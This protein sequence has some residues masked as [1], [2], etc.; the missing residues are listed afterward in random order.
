MQPENICDPGG[1]IKDENVSRLLGE[2]NTDGIVQIVKPLSGSRKSP[3]IENVFKV[4]LL[5]LSGS[6]R[7]VSAV[8]IGDPQNL[9]TEYQNFQEFV[10]KGPLK[11]EH[12]IGLYKPICYL[13]NTGLLQLDFVDLENYRPLSVYYSKEDPIPILELLLNEVLK[14]WHT[15]NN[16]TKLANLQEHIQDQLGSHMDEI[17]EASNMLFQDFSAYAECLI[18]QAKKLV[19]NCVNLIETGNFQPKKNSEFWTISSIVHGDLNFNNIFV[20]DQKKIKL[21]DYEHTGEGFL[22]D[23]LARIECEIKFNMLKHYENRDFWEA[24]I[25]FEQFLLN[26]LTFSSEELPEI[27]KEH[28]EI[29]KAVKC[30]DIVRK[31]AKEVTNYHYKL[32]ESSYWAELLT[33]TLK[34]VGYSG[35]SNSQKKY[36]LISSL[37]IF[38]NHFRPKTFAEVTDHI[39]IPSGPHYPPDSLLTQMTQESKMDIS[40]D[41]KED[42]QLLIRALLNGHVILFLGPEAP[43]EAGAPT[44][45]ELAVKMYDK[46]LGLKPSTNDPEVI[47]DNLLSR[48]DIRDQVKKDIM[49]EYETISVQG[50]YR[51]LPNIRWKRI[52]VDYIDFFV[53]KAYEEAEFS[54]QRFQNRFDPD[55]SREDHDE[56]GNNVVI[57]RVSGSARFYADE[58]RPMRLGAREIEAGK[59]VRIEWFKKLRDIR[60]PI[61]VLFYGYRW[62]DLKKTFFEIVGPSELVDK[63][64]DFYWVSNA[65]SEE[66]AIV[67][68]MA[69]I[70]VLSAEI[71]D[72]LSDI[73]A[74][75]IR[76]IGEIEEKIIIQLGKTGKS[77]EYEFDQKTFENFQQ[78]FEIIH[79]ALEY[80]PNL[81]IGPFF[82]GEEINWRELA[83]G[84][85]VER[86]VTVGEDDELKRA[87]IRELKHIDRPNKIFLLLGEV[88][89]SGTTTILKRTGFDIFKMKEFPVIYL[90]RLDGNSWQFVEDFYRKLEKSHKILILMDNIVAKLEEFYSFS[91]ILQSRRVRS[92]IIA[93]SRLDD[94]N[95]SVQSHFQISGHDAEEEP[96]KIKRTEIIKVSDGLNEKEKEEL[97][98]KLR[99]FEV[100]SE[101]AHHRSGISWLKYSTLLA[102]CWEATDGRHR[103]FEEIVQEYRDKLGEAGR[104]ILD[105][106]C[107]LSYFVS[108][109]VSEIVL[110]RATRINWDKFSLL[111]ESDAMRQL[112]KI[113]SDYHGNEIIGK[114]VPRTMAI[115]D[116]LW[117]PK[118]SIFPDRFLDLL[119]RNLEIREGEPDETDMLFRV[120]S[121]KVL[122]TRLGK[123]SY[124]NRLFE[125]ATA[126]ASGDIRIWHHWG[127][128]LMDHANYRSMILQDINDPTWEESWDKLNQALSRDMRNSAILHSLGMWHL[129]RGKFYWNRSKANLRD[130][131]SF[132]KACSFFDKAKEY[133]EKSLRINPRVEY[134]YNTITNIGLEQL[135]YYKDIG[136]RERFND[137]MMEIHSLLIQCEDNVPRSQQLVLPKS[138]GMWKHLR[139]DKKAAREEYLRY[140]RQNPRNDSVRY[141][142]ANLLLREFRTHDALKEA[143]KIL[144]EAMTEGQKRIGFIKLWYRITEKLYATDYV[145]LEKMLEYAVSVHPEDPFLVSRYAA[146]CFKNEN[147]SEA[148]KHF[149]YAQRLHERD[150]RRFDIC[151]YIWDESLDPKNIEYVWEGKLEVNQLKSFTGNIDQVSYK[152]GYIIMDGGGEK[153]YFDVQMERHNLP[154]PTPG[155]RVI[156]NI[157]FTYVSPKAIEL[158]R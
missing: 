117:S 137:L 23:D 110:H 9:E 6:F 138:M 155:E 106:V 51:Y 45:C 147:F 97:V 65:I 3:K 126:Q 26:D 151:D 93:T 78:Y 18:H 27:A 120:V 131:K 37:L 64:T 145:R 50:F 52:F 84:C 141:L 81:H 80:D 25:E 152:Q 146:A 71:S 58:R 89:G 72:I 13:K 63:N 28:E 129:R 56:K 40:P 29:K 128:V 49:K 38:E 66:E 149:Y 70:R 83:A 33:R 17:K 100:I 95:Q 108:E 10:E 67:A 107:A 157:A 82:E 77:V 30:L 88:A 76:E 36:A 105:I 118:D 15:K 96:G 136:D 57:E 140:L 12:K 109:G 61:S 62:T 153:I 32:E 156:F 112:V 111:I 69:G 98:E 21:I 125:F 39:Q 4:Y 60:L 20:D 90:K 14:P 91:D 113:R 134:A 22:F 135:R 143:E 121:S 2:L 68:R 114:L 154:F 127:I 53:E 119:T 74:T 103:K 123:K 133:F 75:K 7:G 116:L 42:I 92:V 94:W 43:N 130:E 55:E 102:V 142:L 158:S 48:A 148:R 1:W 16:S 35:M 24:L 150:P 86:R 44:K 31:G 139:G 47:F 101:R 34:Y 115:A 54:T 99:K 19:S 41:Q 132:Q 104:L 11:S 122:H 124:K 8:K 144:R 73:Q 87:I 79:D 5:D 46:H 59:P 85:D